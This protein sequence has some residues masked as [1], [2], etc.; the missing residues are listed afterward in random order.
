[1][2]DLD[3]LIRKGKEYLLEPDHSQ[4]S[5]RHYR[6]A[7]ERL[8]TWCEE[9]GIRSYDAD[10][11]SRCF[12]YAGL[13][14]AS[15]PNKRLRS[16]RGFMET[17]ISLEETGAPP[18]R[19]AHAKH[20]VPDGFKEAFAD[21][22]K[23]LASRG[24]KPSTT[25][26]HPSVAR[27]LFASCGESEPADLTA[28]SVSRLA[29]SIEGSTPQARASRPYVVR[30]MLKLLAGMGECA[31]EVAGCLPLMPGRKHSSIPSAYS[32]SELSSLLADKGPP[33]THPK[34]KGS[35]AIM[36]PAGILGMRAS[37]IKGLR[38]QDI[39]RHRKSPSFVQGKTRVGVILPMP[40]EA[41]LAIAE[42]LR[43]ERPDI[44]SDR[45]SMTSCAP[46]R[47]IDSAHALHRELTRAFAA[48]GIDTSGKRHGTRSLRHPAATNMLADK[49][50]YPII[51]A[52][53]GHMSRN[54]ARN[55]SGAEWVALAR[56]GGALGPEDANLWCAATPISA[57]VRTQAPCL[58]VV[59]RRDS[60]TGAHPASA[61]P[62]SR[63]SSPS[64]G[65]SSAIACGSSLGILS[66]LSS[67]IARTIA[68]SPFADTPPSSPPGVGEACD[69]GIKNI[70]RGLT[71]PS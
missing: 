31:P 13:G 39:D 22:E 46:Y 3:D 9:D 53:L 57:S 18:G 59:G 19:A 45:V 7:W 43:D 65:S 29:R 4:S 5:L 54:L 14:E 48:A 41:W 1:M 11:Q 66:R 25:C 63:V 47:P 30:D 64:G 51:S 69:C 16:V 38:L 24:L 33:G 52:T 8:R 60:P 61:S 21:Y 70:K 68:F 35:R 34:P 27:R 37:D 23:E 36:L 2:Y 56:S 26:G 6:I 55:A 20:A 12:A 10:V 17:L 32:R 71:Q 15:N 44:D 67:R 58:S 42:H 28:R 62:A 40:E 50:P 49:I